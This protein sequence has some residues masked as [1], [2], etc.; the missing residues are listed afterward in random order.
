MSY[1]SEIPSQIR[2][3][4]LPKRFALLEAVVIGIVAGIAAIVIKTGVG[5]LGG[6]RVRLAGMGLPEY[7]LPIGGA[8]GGL[9]AGVIIQWVAPEAYGSGVPQVKAVLARVPLVLDLRIALGKLLAAVI[10]IGSG[11]VLGREGPTIQVGAALAAQLSQWFPTSPEYRRQLIAAGAS[12]GL[13]AAFNTPIT[14]VLFVVEA[15][16]Q[17]ASSFS[18]G[19]GVLAA[20]IG[21]L[22]SRYLGGEELSLNGT[23]ASRYAEGIHFYANEIPLYV[24]VGV[25]TGMGGALFNRALMLSSKV[26]RRGVNLPVPARIAVA[27]FIC[28]AI[29]AA[30]PP[31]FRDHAG[32]KSLVS[33]GETDISLTALAIAVH[34]SLTLIA[35]G[36]GSPG[37][38]TA[39]SV[40][41]GS[42]LG[43]LVGHIANWWHLVHHVKTFALVGGGGF[44]CGVARTPISA[45]IIIFELVGNFEIVLPLMIVSVVAYFTAEK[46]YP[47]SIY[48]HILRANGIDLTSKA[49]KEE[50]I[51]AN[52]TAGDVMVQAVETLDSSMTLEE[53]IVAFT[54]SHH[55]GFPV[56]SQGKLVGIVTETDLAIAQGKNLPPHTPL[57]EV[58][59]PDPLTVPPQASLREVLYLLNHYQISR[60]PVTLGREL[61]GIITRSDIIRAESE[62][63]SGQVLHYRQPSYCIYQTRAPSLGRRK[64]LVL[65]NNPKTVATLMHIARSIA[66]VQDYEIECLHVITVHR[67]R[68]PME[69]PVTIGKARRLLRDCQKWAKQWGIDL[70]TQIRTAH[71]VVQAVLDV[72]R[73]DRIGVILLGWRGQ[74]FTPGRVFGDVVDTLIRQAPCHVLVVRLDKESKP[75]GE[76]NRWLVPVAGGPNAQ[77]AIQEFLPGL[78]K[79]GN[80]PH[81]ELCQVFRREQDITDDKLMHADADFLRARTHC[82]VHTN[83]IISP[84]VAE[85][86]IDCA[87]QLEIDTIVL[88]A[89][90]EGFLRQVVQGNIPETIARG[91]PCTVILL[92]AANT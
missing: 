84:A 71:D 38:L 4:F 36:S 88:G 49:D 3:L 41:I 11:I 23:P 32:L 31:T 24:V 64:I 25:L 5:W 83:K 53:T 67:A 37:G 2:R 66:Q 17:D 39:P 43:L 35:F 30:L 85:S 74:D 63:L 14:G 87:R 82:P 12:A 79:L 8:L 50:S 19:T 33:A 89:S 40:I 27:G 92:R 73:E 29:I 13:A 6:W 69:T 62:K 70:H 55:R 44:F 20:F 45:V 54:N 42:G 7:V 9:L 22:I 86:I 65:V 46:V 51:L 48:D 59:T 1:H 18:L 58:M 34:T 80:A 90:R 91:S 75:V 52:L 57:R 28:G 56:L 68:A 47:N 78:V 60:L 26:F 61:V 16:L 77:V 10:S 21:A 81:I 72:T 76:W 15:L